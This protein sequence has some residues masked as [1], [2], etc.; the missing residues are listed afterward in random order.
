MNRF[1]FSLLISFASLGFTNLSLAKG[2]EGDYL[3]EVLIFSQRPSPATT[4]KPSDPYIFQPMTAPAFQVG[5]TPT[6]LKLAN[7]PNLIT[8]LIRPTKAIDKKLTRQADALQR[9][10]NYRLLFHEAWQMR[11]VATDSSLDL[12][13]E[14]G[15]YYSGLPELIGKLTL[16]VERYLH[17]NTA[18]YLNN[19]VEQAA[20][21]A[22]T[23]FN[24]L[25]QI[26]ALQQNNDLA[27]LINAEVSQQLEGNFVQVSSAKMEQRRRMRSTE[28]H[29]IDSPYLGLLIRVDRAPST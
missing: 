21:P 25:T 17:L 3:I 10:K 18:L 11:L 12:L 22:I 26:T 9:N 24:Q 13:I 6:W 15:D 4:E 1:L 29:F 5:A 27:G 23:D 20:Q 7:Q 19:F 2:N 8:N 28:L 14:G 16:S